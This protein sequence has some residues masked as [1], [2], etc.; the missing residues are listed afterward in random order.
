MIR[1][2]KLFSYILILLGALNWGMFGV[3]GT[4]VVAYLFG[5][6]TILSNTIYALIG[7]SAIIN[8]ILAYAD[9]EREGCCC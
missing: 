4:N 8:V 9:C 2:F 5:Q 7:A 1:F 3:F 6:G